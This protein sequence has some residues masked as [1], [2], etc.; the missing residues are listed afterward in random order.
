[1]TT[2]RA[3]ELQNG[4]ATTETVTTAPAVGTAAATTTAHET[5]PKKQKSVLDAEALESPFS[6]L[7]ES[8]SADEEDADM[9]I[10]SNTVVLAL[11]ALAATLL[12]T[13]M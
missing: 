10:S 6:F 3:A 13:I 2:P 4:T 12:S 5:P 8:P 7:K 1:M 9:S 11:K